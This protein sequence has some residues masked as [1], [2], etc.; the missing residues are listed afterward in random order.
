[1]DFLSADGCIDYV[2]GRPHI[3]YRCI[4]TINSIISQQKQNVGTQKNRLNEKFF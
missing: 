1:M 2:V 4:I 3:R